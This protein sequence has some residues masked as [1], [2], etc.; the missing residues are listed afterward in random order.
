[1]FSEEFTPQMMTNKILRGSDS[2][3]PVLQVCSSRLNVLTR[4]HKW[5]EETLLSVCAYLLQD[6]WTDA[7][8]YYRVAIGE[9]LDKRYQ[10]YGYTGQ[11]V[12]SNVVRARDNAR[13]GSEVAIK[14]IRRNDLMHKTGLYLLK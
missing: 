6:N 9:T 8:G 2:Q 3:D 14:I 11:G 13:G 12:F 7:E 10:V 5:K 4:K 1:M